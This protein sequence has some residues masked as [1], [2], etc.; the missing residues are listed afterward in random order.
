MMY[1]G[2]L[3]KHTTSTNIEFISFFTVNG[4]HAQR[5]AYGTDYECFATSVG[6]K[7]LCITG[8]SK[9]FVKHSTTPIDYNSKE[10]EFFIEN[11]KSRHLIEIELI[12]DPYL[13]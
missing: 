3:R 6:R 10:V 12:A 7:G 11:L 8:E 1:K 9:A 2:F 13:D 5:N 4:P